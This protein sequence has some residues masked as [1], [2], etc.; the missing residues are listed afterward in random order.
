MSDNIELIIKRD[1]DRLP[2]LAEERWI[3]SSASSRLVLLSGFADAGVFALVFLFGL[4]LGATLAT[5]GEHAS[6]SAAASA[7]PA[8]SSSVVSSAFLVSR[9]SVLAHVRGLTLLVPRAQ[10]FE[11]K[12]V[13]STDVSPGFS[14]P[15]GTIFWIVAVGGDVQCSFCVLPPS[16]PLHSA[17]FWFD[18]HTGNVLASGQGPANW[19]DGFD[20]LPDR[21]IASGSRTLTGRVV[22]VNGNVVE[23][24]A[25]GSDRLRLRVDD[26]TAFHWSTGLESGSALTV[27]ELAPRLEVV[28][29]VSFDPLAGPGGEFRLEKLIVGVPTN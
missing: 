14:A 20:A 12:L 24:E 26:N 27:A 29:S 21:S 16:Q 6:T 28:V 13:S 17:L 18:A 4:G 8:A 23:F 5:L 19:P 25:V 11:A 3:P 15:A 2:V 7:Q 1:L 22:S 9:H 10:R